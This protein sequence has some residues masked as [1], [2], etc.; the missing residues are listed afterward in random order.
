MLVR[1]T[2]SYASFLWSHLSTNCGSGC[3]PSILFKY[4]AG[5]RTFI[6][7]FELNCLILVKRP[8]PI[9]PIANSVLN[10]FDTLRPFDFRQCLEKISCISTY[11]INVTADAKDTCRSGPSSTSGITGTPTN[12][13]D[14]VMLLDMASSRNRSSFPVRLCHSLV[15]SWISSY[16]KTTQDLRHSGF[17]I[18]LNDLPRGTTSGRWSKLACRVR[19]TAAHP[20]SKCFHQRVILPA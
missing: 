12:E 16:K 9:L 3:A 14:C 17:V 11:K 5:N 1:V 8:S 4:A 2:F 18:E 15:I 7:K 13:P 19:P 20:S 10:Y 6:N